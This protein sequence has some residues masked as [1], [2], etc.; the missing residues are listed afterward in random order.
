MSEPRAKSSACA[1]FRYALPC[2]LAEVPSARRAVRRFLTEQ[3][4]HEEE[5]AACELALAE[6]CNNAIQN[7]RDGG[8][9]HPVEIAVLCT[10][11]KVEISVNDRTPG[12]EWPDHVDLP[13]MNSERGRGLFFI[14]SFM[15]TAQYY[16]G[17][18]ENSLV[19]KKMRCH[20]EHRQASATA[21]LGE[22]QAR[23]EETQEALSDMARELC[24]RTES[25]SAIFRCSSGMGRGK[26]LPELAQQ[27]LNDL[28]HINR[29]RHVFNGGQ[30]RNF[31]R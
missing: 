18:N 22:V 14:Q 23:L 25:L 11:S 2:E 29:K 9:M 7:V 4:L 12:F 21:S 6:A 3:G 24:F 28:L 15:D 1:Q 17:K 27:L 13:D 5:L 16:R 26:N 10:D 8:N 19:M 30:V 20:Q 31:Y